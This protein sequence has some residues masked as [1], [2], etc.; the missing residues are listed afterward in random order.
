M[1]WMRERKWYLKT[2]AVG[3]IGSFFL[4]FLFL[5][6]GSIVFFGCGFRKCLLCK[7]PDK[8]SKGAG[9]VAVDGGI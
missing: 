6:P 8:S 1:K 9:E 7:I 2:M 4:L 3:F 5:P